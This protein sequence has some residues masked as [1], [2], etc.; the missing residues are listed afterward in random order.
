M[1]KAFV[2]LA[3]PFVLASAAHAQSSVTLYGLLDVGLSYVSNEV[4]GHAFK[5]EDS[6]WT[7]SLWGIRG[8]EDLGGGYKT[9]FDLSSQFAVNSGAGIPGPGADF[10]R[11][12]F[13]G[14]GKR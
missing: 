14:L 2:C 5:A 9:L 1:K 4:G 3:S 6:I 12:A 13:V 11:Q 7:P 10:N 8:V